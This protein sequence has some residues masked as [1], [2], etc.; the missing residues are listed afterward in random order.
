MNLLLSGDFYLFQKQSPEMFYRKNF[1]PK[2]RNIHWNTFVL[3]SLF[4]E[5]SGLRTATLLKETPTQVFSCEY[6]Q[7]FKNIYFE[8]HLQTAASKLFLLE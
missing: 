4:N 5:V 8:E 7:I 3:E 2:Y 6:Y 1:S